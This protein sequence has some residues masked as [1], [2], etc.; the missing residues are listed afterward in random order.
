MLTVTKLAMSLLLN[1]M[2]TSPILY[3]YRYSIFL[4]QNI[5]RR[6]KE[7][8]RYR[9]TGTC[10]KMGQNSSGTGTSTGISIRVWVP[11]LF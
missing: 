3:R 11:E 2:D 5:I 7:R 6:E 8:G 10:F 4:S 9:Y 1:I